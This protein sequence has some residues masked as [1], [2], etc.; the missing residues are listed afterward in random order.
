MALVAAANEGSVPVPGT[1]TCRRCGKRESERE[2]GNTQLDKGME[3]DGERW[4]SS[5]TRKQLHHH[6]F[7]AGDTEADRWHPKEPDGVWQILA[8]DAGQAP[9]HILGGSHPAGNW[10]KHLMSTSSGDPGSHLQLRT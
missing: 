6:H 2:R 10:G 7:T 4:V 8:S 1:S 3:N 9:E 5:I